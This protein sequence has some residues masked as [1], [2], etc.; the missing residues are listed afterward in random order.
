[1]IDDAT[2]AKINAAITES[3][4]QQVGSLLQ[5]RL[6][7]ADKLEGERDA[8][9]ERILRLSQDIETQERML[10]SRAV[11]IVELLAKPTGIEKREKA[12]ADAERQILVANMERRE[13]QSV[14]M[15]VERVVAMVFKNPEV[16][17]SVTSTV[18]RNTSTE[19]R[20]GANVE[21]DR[22]ETRTETEVKTEE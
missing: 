3:L 15:A 4:P 2:Q 9:R 18:G 14:A 10:T 19:W 6:K 7:E 1:M 20:N 8:L 17:R 22:G 16:R 5:A 21:V 12:V 11:E 13:A